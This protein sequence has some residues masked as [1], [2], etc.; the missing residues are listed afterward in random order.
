MQNSDARVD[1]DHVV[2]CMTSF[3]VTPDLGE[4]TVQALQLAFWE[5]SK[6]TGPVTIEFPKGRYDLLLLSGDSEELS[7]TEVEIVGQY[8]WQP[9]SVL[10]AGQF[11]TE[12]MPI[13]QRKDGYVRIRFNTCQGSQWRVNMLIINKNYTYL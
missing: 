8:R 11:A 1:T 6:L 4:D 3:G 12:I 2:L 7:Y 5:A 13:T 10:K 9:E